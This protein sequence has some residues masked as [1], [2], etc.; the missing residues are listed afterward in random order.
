M[1]SFLKKYKMIVLVFLVVACAIG[2]YG[3]KK[4]GYHVDEMYSYG[5]ANSE[6]LP[7]L[8]FG[9]HDY[10]VKDWMN[11]YGPGENLAQFARNLVN[12]F[13]I[14]K[15][16]DFQFKNSVIYQDYRIAQANSNNTR[17][18]TWMD[19]QEYRDYLTA[20]EHNAF[21]LASV[22]Y[23]QR[24]DVHPPLFYIM[25]HLVSS[26]F[27][28]VFSKWFGIV[29]NGIYLLAALWIWYRTIRKHMGGEQLA[30]VNLLVW[31][32]SCGF[33]T[34]VLLIRMYALLTLWCVC[35]FS[36]HLDIVEQKFEPNKKTMR[37]LGLVTFLGFYTHY[38]FV[39]YAIG[40]AA[41]MVVW[42]LVQ[43]KYKSILRYVLRLALSAVVGLC[44]WP[45]AIS[46]VFG[47]YR[48]TSSLAALTGGFYLIRVKLIG[49][50]IL[51]QTIHCE[52]WLLI[53][54]ALL[55]VGGL[56]LRKGKNIPYGKLCLLV[57]PIVFYVGTVSQIVPFLT[58]R[59][60]M[61]TYPFVILTITGSMYYGIKAICDRKKM[62]KK[63]GKI[64]T[65][66][67]ALVLCT[68]LLVGNGSY[69]FYAPGYLAGGQETI[70]VPEHTDAVYVLPDGDWNESAFHT[71]VLARCEQ[72]GVC[73]LSQL[74]NLNPEGNYEAP[75]YVYVFIQKDMD[76]AAVLE[77]V[78]TTLQLA[79]YT[80]VKSE[81]DS[82]ATGIL[83]KRAL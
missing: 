15:D 20:D 14:L 54:A 21:H 50:Y 18:T 83:L 73:Y 51:L 43:K 9:D 10:T 62:P 74:G 8:H 11:T 46:H 55:G 36:I 68:L 35:A 16:C 80:E 53:L 78:K 7:F 81:T 28:G 4:Q 17:Q 59:Y 77:Q 57:L 25:L 32:L 82:V 30:R 22:Y 13:K 6:Y 67:V 72:V 63:I 41:V 71:S 27:Q 79:N 12:D 37:R 42:M 3:N 60:V 40:L 45:F 2:Y 39:L 65:M 23:N 70:Q 48:G 58:D 34:C 56:V 24:G 47:G 61:C 52:Y 64:P 19:G 49:Y 26:V 44:V 1:V 33:M 5:L 31:G 69:L 76:V 38:Y 66:Y 75:E 29:L